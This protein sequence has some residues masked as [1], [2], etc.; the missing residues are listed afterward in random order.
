ML[1]HRIWSRPALLVLPEV[2]RDEHVG[3][4]VWDP[5][6]KAGLLSLCLGCSPCLPAL[7]VTDL[8][9]ST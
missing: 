3:D 2:D 7:A 9:L 6:L 5:G 4:K 1:P 8:C